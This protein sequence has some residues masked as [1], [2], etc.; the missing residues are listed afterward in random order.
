[1]GFNTM[2]YSASEVS[3]KAAVL[4]VLAEQVQAPGFCLVAAARTFSARQAYSHAG[5]HNQGLCCPPAEQAV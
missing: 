2:I 5:V 3:S 1:M 4:H